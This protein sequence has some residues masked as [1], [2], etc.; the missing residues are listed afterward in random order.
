MRWSLEKLP[1][2]SFQRL[3][4]DPRKNRHDNDLSLL[5]GLHLEETV[6]SPSDSI[7]PLIT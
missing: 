6:R 2:N 4:N 3:P 7:P 5:V 1:A